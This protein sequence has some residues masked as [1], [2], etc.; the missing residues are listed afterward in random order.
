MKRKSLSH[1]DSHVA[2]ALEVVGE[3]WTLLVVHCVLDGVHR[4]EAIHKELGIARNILTDRLAT[5]VEAEVMEK[6]QYNAKPARY[7]Y[8]LTA[9]GHDL[10][11]AVQAL[12]AWG[13]KWVV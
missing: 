13:K 9:K 11:P 3:W 5:L 1:L 8:H 2:S 10:A 7:E 12:A 6:R 4:F